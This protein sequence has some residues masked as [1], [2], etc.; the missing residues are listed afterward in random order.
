MAQWLACTPLMRVS[1]FQAPDGSQKRSLC[2]RYVVCVYSIL[3]RKNAHR[4]N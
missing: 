4:S 3:K 2:G 1:W